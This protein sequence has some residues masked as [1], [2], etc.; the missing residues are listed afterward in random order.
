[1]L[2]NKEGKNNDIRQEIKQEER[3][4]KMATVA[5]YTLLITLAAL[6]FSVF[7]LIG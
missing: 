5:G 2:S 4:V 3:V 1:M 6:S 7:R